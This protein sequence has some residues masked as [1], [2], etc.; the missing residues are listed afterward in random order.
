M[1]PQE[2]CPICKLHELVFI[3]SGW[4]II[5]EILLSSRALFLSLRSN[6]C[7]G[8]NVLLTVVLFMNMFW[9]LLHPVWINIK[10]LKYITTI[11]T[12]NDQC[13]WSTF[14]QVTFFE[15]IKQTFNVV[16]GSF[17]IFPNNTISSLKNSHCHHHCHNFRFFHSYHKGKWLWWSSC[18]DLSFPV[19]S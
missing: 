12:E 13:F 2:Y 17:E 15:T 3:T 14:S 6:A 18:S 4:F 9:S 7:L 16:K 8:E 11:F 1:L 5:G 19:V 10:D